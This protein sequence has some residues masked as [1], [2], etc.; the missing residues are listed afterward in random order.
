M[1]CDQSCDPLCILYRSYGVTF[2]YPTYID[3]LSR[4]SLDTSLEDHNCNHTLFN[5]TDSNGDSMGTIEELFCAC[6]E[7]NFSNITLENVTLNS[8]WSF[9][10]SVSNLI[11]R[12][13]SFKEVWFENV[14]LEEV[15]FQDVSFLGIHIANSTWRDVI[16]S[17]VTFDN[18]SLCSVTSEGSVFLSTVFTDG[19]FN[20]IPLDG[21]SSAE[22]QSIFN[23]QSLTDSSCSGNSTTPTSCFNHQ[24]KVDLRREYFFDFLIAG[25]AF[26]GN[27]VSA[28]AVYL[29]RRSFWLGEQANTCWISC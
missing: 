1:S 28:I 2:W 22:L 6:P 8:W 15:Y 25:S 7:T 18:A 13:G 21:L 16:F 3:R 17:N 23:N 19:S 27:V 5:Y 11:V 10:T 4:E 26:P 12:G 20:G 29:F 9:D 24:E 14:S